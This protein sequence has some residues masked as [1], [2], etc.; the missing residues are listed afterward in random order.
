MNGVDAS[1]RTRV[2]E[3][4]GSLARLGELVREQGTRALLVTDPGLVASGHV[5]RA[6]ELL[7]ASDVEVHRFAET[8]ENP[9]TQD[10][11]RCATLAR[12]VE[13]DVLVGFGGGSSIDVAKGANFVW[14]GGGELSDY[15]GRGEGELDLA[16]LVA[17]P[18]TAG[19]G[20]EVQSFALIADEETHAKMACGHPSAAPRVAL[21]D[22]ELTVTQPRFVTACTGLDAI[23]HAVEVAVTTRGNE[24]S[25]AHARE[26]FAL[27]AE[28]FPRV[29]DAPDDLDAR[30]KMLRAAALAG[31]GIENSMLGAAHSMANPLTAHFDVPH[32]QAVATALPLVVSYNAAED[33]SLDRYADLAR[34]AGLVAA[35]A[36]R[37]EACRALVT[38]LEGYLDRAGLPRGWG[39][40][41]VGE[42]DCA[43][44]AGEAATQWTAQ[45]NPRAIGA[46]EFTDLYRLG[47]TR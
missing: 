12:E 29:L 25:Y 35:S 40:L 28:A 26:A 27:A 2:V 24:V 46:E 5:A 47:V 9:T 38:T 43:R 18:T 14:R 30:A 34:A 22:A 19:T 4:V 32:G 11:A 39:A 3:G 17:V 23:G 15:L 16:P 7:R 42:G 13:P 8:R 21:L 41:G 45:F 33:E 36:S 37:D 20:T 1:A 44:L 31:R 10:V 6:E